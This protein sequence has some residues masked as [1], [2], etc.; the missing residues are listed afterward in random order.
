MKKIC[1]LISILSII[2]CAS[3][4][5][6]DPALLN[7]PFSYVYEFKLSKDQIY[8]RSLVWFA[9]QF[10]S[11]NDVLQLKDKPNGKIIGRG[12][13]EFVYTLFPRKYLYSVRVDIKDNKARLTF[14]NYQP[15]KNG[16]TVGISL[17]WKEAYTSVK[18]NFDTLAE[19]Y[20]KTI[21]QENNT[22]F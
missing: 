7:K 22:D 1:L 18:S 15:V 2:S 12:A 19:N 3:A 9:E 6:T 17:E 8:D 4:T 21:L 11:S 5:K 13:G 10:I 14:D 16:E 20:K